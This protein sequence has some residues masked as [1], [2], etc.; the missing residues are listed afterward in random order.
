MKTLRQAAEQALEALEEIHFG[1]MTPMAEKNWNKAIT[2]LQ[3]A[4]AEEKNT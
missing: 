4:L 2:A 1:N 3:E